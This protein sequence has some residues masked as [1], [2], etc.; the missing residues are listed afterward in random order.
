MTTVNTQCRVTG[1]LV[2]ALPPDQ[3]FLLFTP[4]GEQE[5]VPQWKPHF[6]AAVADDTTPGTVFETQA[7]GPTTTWVVVDSVSGR[8]IRYAR[9]TPQVDAGT[10]TVA[11]DDTDGH[12]EVT[13]TYELTPLTE[14]AH[15]HVEA[16]A[17]HFPA[18]L[19]SWEEAIAASLAQRREL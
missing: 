7:H 4:R 1:R 15:A 9:V 5:W 17:V 18:F 12:S 19:Q 13:V 11:L 16:F 3:A 8:R 10:V 2:V 14:A 6:A